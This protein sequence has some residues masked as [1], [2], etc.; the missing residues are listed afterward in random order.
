M[1]NPTDYWTAW[2]AGWVSATRSMLQMQQRA[3]EM[4]LPSRSH[5]QASTGAWED[6][7]TAATAGD[8][9]RRRGRPRKS[10]SAGANTGRRRRGRP[11]KNER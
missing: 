3:M 10:E 8:K 7:M 11:R 4:M 1:Q 6:A 2:M 9:P 5:G